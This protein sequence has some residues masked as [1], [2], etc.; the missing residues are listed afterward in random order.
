MDSVDRML[1]INDPKETEIKLEFLDMPKLHSYSEE[2]GDN[3]FKALADS[4]DIELFA[5]K[6]I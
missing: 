4:E 1:F 6:S 3:F 5:Y 2:T